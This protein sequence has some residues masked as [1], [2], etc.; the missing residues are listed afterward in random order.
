MDFK[1]YYTTLGVPKKASADEIQKAYRKLARKYHPDVNRTP[2]AEDKFKEIT[3]SY[4]VLKDPEKRQTYDQFGKNWKNYQGSGGMP[5]GFESIFSGAGGNSG[6]SSF[7]EGLF[8]GGGSRFAGGDPFGGGGF[9]PGS[10]PGAGLG[11]R[12]GQ[13][14]EAR[15]AL[16]VEEA[17][18]GGGRDVSLVDPTTGETKTYSINLPRGVKA[19]QKIRLAGR[20]G[21]GVGSGQAGH[22]YLKVELKPNDRFRL[23]DRDL[24]TDLPVSPWE[25]ALGAEVA[26]GT[27]EG[28][29][30]LRIPPGSSSGRKLRLRG[31]GFP[32]PKGVDGDLYAEI[33]IVVPEQLSEKERELF[34]N[35]AETSSFTA[36]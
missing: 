14:Q 13:D 17:A 5:P 16:T 12:R 27:L 30:T 15:L 31:R 18:K 4:E 28:P 23:E 2:E 35:L 24:Y 7:F 29:V 11:G 9:R 34:E 21:A 25:A 20:G 26:V 33:K 1:D 6:F 19:G 36:R 32:N 22:L 3:E 10:S 8:G